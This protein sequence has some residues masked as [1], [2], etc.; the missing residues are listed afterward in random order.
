MD[1]PSSFNEYLQGSSSTGAQMDY[2]LLQRNA[3]NNTGRF[4]NGIGLNWDDK[5]LDWMGVPGRIRRINL[6]MATISEGDDGLSSFQ[7]AGRNFAAFIQVEP[8]AQL[9]SKWLEGLGF[10]MG[11]WFCNID[12]KATSSN[13]CDTLQLRDNG[14]GGR[15]VLFTTGDNIGRGWVHALSPGMQ[16]VVGPYRLRMAK[17]YMNWDTNGS[18]RGAS[19]GVGH[20]WGR[21]WIIAHELFLWSPKGFLTGSPGTP[22]S[23]LFG[24]HFER[25]DVTC[26]KGGGHGGQS[27]GVNTQEFQRSTVL[28]REWDLYYFLANQISIGITWAWYDASNLTPVARNN[29]GLGSKDNPSNHGGDWLD[30]NL[31][32]R[33]RF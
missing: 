14:D 20:T 9:K 13:G 12:G 24:W 23:V 15:Q 31:N 1:G 21:G 10:S 7:D 18:D 22:G 19:P 33:Y 25:N 11:G 4:G 6:V 5:P 2:L 30:I 8:F 17:M 3:G 27:C 28:L 32:F 29:L 26:D 16:W